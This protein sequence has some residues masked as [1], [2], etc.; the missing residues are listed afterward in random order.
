M[1]GSLG[2]E[3]GP[4]PL[5]G[6][7]RISSALP[8]AIFLPE[9]MT[10]IRSETPMTSRITCSIMTIVTPRSSRILR[11][12]SSSSGHAVDRKPDSGLIKQHDLGIADQ[13]PCDLDNPLLGRTTTRCRAGR[14]TT[15]KPTILSA[16]MARSRISASSRRMPGVR[17]TQARMPDFPERVNSGHHVFQ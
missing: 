15:R 9:F 12:N 2:A 14:Q 10:T 3:I 4:S 16:S 17:S 5:P 1:P 6:C 7:R 8:S 11:S 13:C